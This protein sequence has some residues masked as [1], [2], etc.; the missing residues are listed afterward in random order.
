MDV[1]DDEIGVG[2]LPVDRDRG[3]HEARNAAD[4]EQ[5]DEAREEQEGVR[6][7]GRPVQIVASQA[8]TATRARDGDDHARRR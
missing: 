8:N 7:T 2:E 1:R 6:N 4:H 3:G 5:H